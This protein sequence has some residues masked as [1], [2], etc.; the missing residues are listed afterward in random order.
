MS[1]LL[2]F[3]IVKFNSEAQKATIQ[4]RDKI[5]R[6]P[7]GM[8]FTAEQLADEIN[9]FHL[10]G[11]TN[12][13]LICC[14]VLQDYDEGNLKMRQVAVDDQHQKK[15]YGQQMTNWM[16]NWA[17]EKNYKRIFCHARDIAVPFYEK[18]HYK[19]YGEQFVEVG[20][21]HFKMEKFL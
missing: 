16:E 3:E 2:K 7:L 21:P 12:H 6:K 15:G 8:H 19:V 4:L 17:K 18:L 14:M 13:I 10:A 20:I 9:M 11:Y 1:E 5:L